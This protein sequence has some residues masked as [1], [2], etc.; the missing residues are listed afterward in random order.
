MTLI[1]PTPTSDHPARRPDMSDYVI[2]VLDHP[3]QLDQVA[4]AKTRPVRF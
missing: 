2:Q 4:Y 3:Q 1:D